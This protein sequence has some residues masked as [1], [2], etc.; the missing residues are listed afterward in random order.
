MKIGVVGGTGDC[1]QG[2]TLRWAQGHEVIVG[3]R[4]A[5]KAEQF[6]EEIMEDL[7]GWG[8]SK[9]K[10]TGTDNAG[11]IEAS[12][13]VVLAV[14]YRFVETVTKDLK[15]SYSDQIVLSP[16]VPMG[17]V[18]KHFEYSPPP[19]GCASFQ[20]RDLLPPSVRIVAAF[21]TVSAAIFQDLNRV[22][23]GDVLICGDDKEAKKVVSGLVEE[24]RDLHPLD[25]GP[26]AV[27][28]MLE[29]LTPM[30]LNI[31]RLNKLKNA[32]IKIVEG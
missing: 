30:L 15:D 29:G 25:A 28:P 9:P 17:R 16:V 10:V 31:S 21:H 3:S 8:M 19:Q 18:E 32:G 24:I 6:A 14:P 1:G 7:K 23:H 22:I 20:I 26:L 11:A 27:S 12:D 4:K 13:L 2:F 5:E